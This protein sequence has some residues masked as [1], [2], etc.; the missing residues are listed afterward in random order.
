M[1]SEELYYQLHILI[2]ENNSLKNMKISKPHFVQLFNREALKWV[3]NKLR[4]SNNSERINA[5]QEL[6]NT[7]PLLQKTTTVSFTEFELPE[8][9]YWYASTSVVFSKGNCKKIGY[10]DLVHPK[11]PEIYLKDANNS[12]SFDWNYSI[13]ELTNSTY[14]VYKDDFTIDS[15]NLTYWKTPTKID[16]A[17]Y[18][19]LVNGEDSQDIDSELSEI[20][21]MEILDN[22]CL[23]IARE[24]ENGN[25]FQLAQTRNAV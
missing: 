21:L 1:K 12:P 25:T 9:Y 18:K 15:V 3:D 2:A 6:L 7:A 20:Y 23:E 13:A 8:N 10:V 24:F 14:K 17:G 19:N 22:V 16:L 11:E 5:L 4:N